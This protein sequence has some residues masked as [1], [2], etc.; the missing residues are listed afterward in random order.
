MKDEVAE[1]VVTHRPG[2]QV[3]S[4]FATFP[5]TSF[6]KV[7]QNAHFPTLFGSK[8]IPHLFFFC[9][10]AKEE[11]KGDAVLVGRVMMPCARGQEEVHRLVLS[12]TQLQ[13]VHR[14]L[15]T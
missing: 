9:S 11:K 3:S 12:K 13:R 5:C 4:D 14:L 2:A 10:Q 7:R 1:H 8:K 6:V 15:Q